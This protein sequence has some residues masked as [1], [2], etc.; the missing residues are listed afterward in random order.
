MQVL[1]LSTEKPLLKLL[2]ER[3]YTHN[4]RSSQINPHVAVLGFTRFLMFSFCALIPSIVPYRYEVIR[5]FTVPQ[6]SQCLNHGY[7]IRECVRY[8]G[9][10]LQMPQ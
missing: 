3:R 9:V 8:Q 4:V 10:C 6:L 2:N 5:I 7:G 1:R